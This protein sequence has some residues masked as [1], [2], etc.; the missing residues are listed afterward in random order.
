MGRDVCVI[1]RE[2]IGLIIENIE[3]TDSL[4]TR[5]VDYLKTLMY[6]NHHLCAGPGDRASLVEEDAACQ[7]PP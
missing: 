4:P 3:V 1:L 5:Q 7:D 2:Q 6:I